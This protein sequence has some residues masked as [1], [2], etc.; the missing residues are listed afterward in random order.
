MADLPGE[1]EAPD[2]GSDPTSTATTLERLAVERPGLTPGAILAARFRIVSL[3]GRGG[4]GEVYRAE[5]LKLGQPVALKFLPGPID[6]KRLERFYGEVRLG[7]QVAHPNVCRIYDVIEADG[8]HFL[9]MEYVDGEDLASLL[10]R[11]GRLPQ[12]KAT[13]IARGLCAGLAAAHEKGILHRDLKP[14]NVMLDGRG[15]ARITDFGLAA[16]AGET[17]K[18]AQAGTPAYMAPE[19]LR[20]EALSIRT[21]LYSLGLVFYE[22]Y[23]GRRAWDAESMS[24]LLKKRSDSSPATPSSWVKDLDPAVERLILRCLER[25]PAARPE[26]ALAVLAA[27]PGGDPLQAAIALGETPSPEMVAAA[28]VVG[29][30]KPAVA[31]GLLGAAALLVTGAIWL[32]GRVTLH[33]LA[34]LPKST[35]VLLDRATTLAE[36]LAPGD[37]VADSGSGI[38]F[39]GPYLLAI[40]DRDRSPTRWKRL[41]VDRPGPFRFWYRS[42]P[43]PLVARTWTPRA[44]WRVGARPVGRLTRQ[45]PPPLEPGMREVV[46]DTQGRLLRW[47]RLPARADSPEASLDATVGFLFAEAGLDQAKFAVTAA[48]SNIWR[49][50]LQGARSALVT[51]EAERGRLSLFDVVADDS[52]EATT[53]ASVTSAATQDVALKSLLGGVILVFA[54]VAALVVRN[55]RARRGDRKGAFRVALFGFLTSDA[56]LKL[57]VHFPPSLADAHDLWM[58]SDAQAVYWAVWAWVGYIALEPSLRRTW[59]HTL[60]SWSRLMAGR[61]RDPLVGRDV[62]VGVI[63]GAS[64]VCLLYSG[65]LIPVALGGAPQF[66]FISAVPALSATREALAVPL[67]WLFVSV[68]LALG[69][70]LQLLLVYQL[71]RSRRLA[72]F[73]LWLCFFIVFMA[74]AP[75][76]ASRVPLAGVVS[77][78]VVTVVFRFGLLASAVMLYSGAMLQYLPLT[79]DTSAWYFGASALGLSIVLV[80]A[81]YG[82]IVSLA[83]KP[84]FGRPVLDP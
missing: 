84:F 45:Q 81:G 33:G 19:Q 58:A 25:D 16:L 46:L 9:V 6:E 17:H 41:A 21:D 11:I 13:E 1:A 43:A 34:P 30:L 62:L 82:F 67:H 54:G 35:E 65:N 53:A 44:M 2:A 5:D 38:E 39:D 18:D 22:I 80:L 49:G 63:G 50:P 7:R 57:S 47:R 27:L 12:D 71:G 4:M 77:A 74:G 55:L 78:M 48:A 83:G 32:A 56:A 61:F 72:L 8:R 76:L 69:V 28:S 37:T 14:A 59:P 68:L 26:N 3:L 66:P 15:Q 42:S 40:F 60:I 52:R 75:D 24:E 20:G 70:L 79:A 51:I 36:R 23:C 29:D 73:L 10:R 31:W 64:Y